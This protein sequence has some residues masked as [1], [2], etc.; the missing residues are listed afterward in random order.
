MPAFPDV[1]EKLL[2]DTS[3]EPDSGLLLDQS[4]SGVVRKRVMYAAT[5]FRLTLVYGGLTDSERT[6]ME[7]FYQTN[8]TAT[9]ITQDYKGHTYTGQFVTEMESAYDF[10]GWG[11]E[12]TIEGTRA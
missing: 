9:D 3:V 5:R 2:I 11:I 12:V 6:T 10:G 4:D 7:A 8:K 1:S